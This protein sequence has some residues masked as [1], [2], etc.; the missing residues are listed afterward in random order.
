MDR[1]NYETRVTA[2]VSRI[3]SEDICNKAK[4]AAINYLL[5]EGSFLR[6]EIDICDYVA[7]VACTESKEKFFLTII[8]IYK[9][10]LKDKEYKTL[11]QQGFSDEAI[12][13][14]RDITNDN[15]L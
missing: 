12:S 7:K 11:K 9:K 10:P 14:L 4:K 2:Q 5:R 15:L 1:I 8:G 3:W 13:L 6:E